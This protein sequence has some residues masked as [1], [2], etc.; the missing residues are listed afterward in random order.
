M[1]QAVMLRCAMSNQIMK[2][3]K[4]PSTKVIECITHNYPTQ[5]KAFRTKVWAPREIAKSKRVGK[6]PQG[7][8]SLTVKVGQDTTRETAFTHRIDSAKSLYILW[9]DITNHVN[10]HFTCLQYTH[11]GLSSYWE[12]GRE[13]M[14][15]LDILFKEILA[16]LWSIA[17][18]YIPLK[19]SEKCFIRG[20]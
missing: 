5:Y 17:Q 3:S 16:S 6:I 1:H 8:N 9:G 20:A 10:E 11:Q 18:C 14:W 7:N 15:G 4:K 19:L 12:G 2:V 13:S